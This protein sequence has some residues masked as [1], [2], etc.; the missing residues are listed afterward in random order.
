M[1][2]GGGTGVSGVVV[3]RGM[4]E[5]VRHGVDGRV[6]IQIES[7]TQHSTLVHDTNASK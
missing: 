3:N 1:R 2:D 5:R 7:R 6:A 4:C